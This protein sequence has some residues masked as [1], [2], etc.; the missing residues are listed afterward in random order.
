MG[1]R[2]EVS[3]KKGHSLLHGQDDMVPTGLEA[4]GEG[5]QPPPAYERS[6]AQEEVSGPKAH[7]D[8][9]VVA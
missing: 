7:W 9:K 3:G 8:V 1:G 5:S 6:P 4:K 2:E